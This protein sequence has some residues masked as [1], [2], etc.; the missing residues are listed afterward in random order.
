MMDAFNFAVVLSSLRN[1]LDEVSGYFV[2]EKRQKSRTLGFVVWRREGW[3][4]L[5]M[6]FG[7]IILENL[8]NEEEI[9]NE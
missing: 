3:K 2:K 9:K 5:K 7:H 6:S 8:I 4:S 1:V